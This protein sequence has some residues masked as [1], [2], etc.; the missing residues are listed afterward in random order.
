MLFNTVLR[1][2]FKSPNPAINV[3]CTD[4]PLATDK[5]KLPVPAISGGETYTLFFVG[6]RSLLSSIHGMM[7]PAQTP[8]ELTDEIIDFGAPTK[9]I[10]DSAQV[11]NQQGCL[12]YLLHVWCLQMAN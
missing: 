12:Q 11:E 8:G 1:K 3:S 5:I 7:T 10:S 9:L 6:T 4:E 2:P